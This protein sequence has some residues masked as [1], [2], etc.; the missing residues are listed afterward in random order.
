MNPKKLNQLAQ[1]LASSQHVDDYMDS[2]QGKLCKMFLFDELSSPQTLKIPFHLL[3]T[4]VFTKH[5]GV[6]T[7]NDIVLVVGVSYEGHIPTYSPQTTNPPSSVTHHYDKKQLLLSQIAVER[8]KEASLKPP[9]PP[10][11][12]DY[13]SNL[14]L[15]RDYTVVAVHPSGQTISFKCYYSELRPCLPP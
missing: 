13:T 14:Y 7:H 3:G 15:A 8:G 6:L 2:L 5:N 9:T 11:A 12:V 4:T 1:K 10:I